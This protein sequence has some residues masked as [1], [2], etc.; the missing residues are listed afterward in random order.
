MGRSASDPGFGAGG[1]VPLRAVFSLA[2]PLGLTL[3]GLIALLF[4]LHYH[5][6][7]DRVRQHALDGENRILELAQQAVVQEVAGLLSDLRFL[8]EQNEMREFLR[9]DVPAARERL[10]AEYLTFVSQKPRY[11]QVAVIGTDGWEVVRIDGNA[12]LAALANAP[13]LESRGDC[14]HFQETMRLGRGEVHLSPLDL[15][16][17]D[18]AVQMPLSPV[19]RASVPLFGPDGERRGVLTLSYHGWHLVTRLRAYAQGGPSQLWLLNEQGYWLA[20]PEPALEWGFVFPERSDLTLAAREPE[21]WERIR[22]EVA[23]TVDTADGLLTFRRVYPLAGDLSASDLPAMASPHRYSWTLATLLPHRALSERMA[24]L[25][26]TLVS[27]YTVTAPLIFGGTL[28]LMYRSARGRIQ[29]REAER[30]ERERMLE[31]AHVNRLASVGELAT[32]M[33]HQ[34]NQPLTA[35]VTYCA[36]AQRS[37]QS[38]AGD[39]SRLREWVD[40]IGEE[41]QRVSAIVRGLREFVRW[42]KMAPVPLDIGEVVAGVVGVLCPD[43][44]RRR[45]KL[46]VETHPDL[47][48][49]LADR[50]LIAQVL[51]N[52]VRNAIEAVSAEPPDRRRVVVSLAPAGQRV[53]VSVA[54]AGPGVDPEVAGRLFD[55]FVTTKSDG[56]GIGLS[57][58]RSIV[59]AHGGQLR[60]ELAPSGGAVFS[61]SLRRSAP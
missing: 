32:Q 18:G 51:L 29:L 47:P 45:V 40:A 31:L 41:A 30:R 12:G 24:G 4:F 36:A 19:L 1:R 22:A 37:L 44:D 23:G 34:V 11:E 48:E 5:L 42:G 21:A 58:T 3:C 53:T 13:A 46:N 14:A 57:I 27:I 26:G 56:L 6:E 61:F 35:I 15:S 52:L 59:E 54:D 17:R 28:W 16:L 39:P 8:H 7:T 9:G 2:V 55:S 33:A 25:A 60:Y 10:A 50:V 38:G 20:G 43:A 49:V